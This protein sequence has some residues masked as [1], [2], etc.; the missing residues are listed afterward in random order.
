[1]TASG[2]QHHQSVEGVASLHMLGNTASASTTG[3]T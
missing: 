2:F 1:M 3:S